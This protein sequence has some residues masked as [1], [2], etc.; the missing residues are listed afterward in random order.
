MLQEVEFQPVDDGAGVHVR[1]EGF[2]VSVGRKWKSVQ[3]RTS[4]VIRV[5]AF[6]D[7]HERVDARID[8]DGIVRNLNRDGLLRFEGRDNREG[9]GRIRHGVEGTKKRM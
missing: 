9:F 6:G 8:V 4:D 3:C 1:P 2:K 7:R 5:S